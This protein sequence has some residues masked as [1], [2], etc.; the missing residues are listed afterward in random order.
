MSRVGSRPK[1]SSPDIEARKRNQRRRDT[2]PE[3]LLRSALWR[4]GLRYC[5]VNVVGRRRKVDLAL[6][7]SKVAVFV[8]GCFW[9]RCPEHGSVPRANRV[10]WLAKLDANV[11][12]DLDSNRELTSAGWLVIRVWEHEDPVKAADRIEGEVR[13]RGSG[14]C[15]SRD[16]I[17]EVV[18]EAFLES[19]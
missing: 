2:D 7:R 3:K 16:V 1:P 10:W 17:G 6:T 15:D 8:D 5:V 13:R 18:Q 11:E 19:Q 12:R 4:R 14:R 9:H